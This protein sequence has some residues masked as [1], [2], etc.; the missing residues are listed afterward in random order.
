MGNYNKWNRNEA[1]NDPSTPINVVLFVSR[2]KDNKEL[3]NFKERRN[4]TAT[5]RKRKETGFDVTYYNPKHWHRV[6]TNDDD[7]FVFIPTDTGATLLQDGRVLD[8]I[9]F[10]FYCQPLNNKH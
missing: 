7:H 1:D 2:N 4:L 6:D 8:A 5:L 10:A 3:Q 9:E